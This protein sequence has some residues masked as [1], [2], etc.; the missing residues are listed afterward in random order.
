MLCIFFKR[1][2]ECKNRAQRFFAPCRIL[3]CKKALR[4]IFALRIIGGDKKIGLEDALYI[5]QKISGV[6]K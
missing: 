4:S 5:L 3:R 6:Q 1:F 2:P